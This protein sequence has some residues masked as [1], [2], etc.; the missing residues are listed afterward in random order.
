MSALKNFS[1]WIYL[2]QQVHEAT[3]YIRRAEEL[4]HPHLL[5]SYEAI[6]EFLAYFRSAL[7][8]YARC[9]VSAGAGRIRL[10]SSSVFVN[11]KDLMTTHDRII[12]LR[13][14]YVSHSDENEFESV[15]VTEED[16]EEELVLHLQYGISFPFD[17]LYDLR[18]LIRFV[19]LSIVDRQ[20][21]HISAIER[22]V[23]KP[24]RVLEGSAGG[25]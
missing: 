7:N 21:S 17:R 13:H 18:D 20:S 9:F 12:D 5:Q 24:V 19:E 11:D 3:Y 22:E 23:G 15:T 2:M 25:A 6:L 8:S 14:K 4:G 16:C 10:E 1:R